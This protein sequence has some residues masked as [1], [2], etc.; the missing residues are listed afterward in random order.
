MHLRQLRAALDVPL[1][2]VVAAARVGEVVAVDAARVRQEVADR[3]GFGH[4]LVGHPEAGQIAAHGRVELDPSLVD[5]LHDEGRGPD[6]GDRADLEQGVGRRLDAGVEVEDSGGR[7]VD[8]VAA[9]DG[10]RGRRHAVSL[11]Q[12]LEPVPEHG[13]LR[14]RRHGQR[15]SFSVSSYRAVPSMLGAMGAK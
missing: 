1:E 14:R 15:A 8:L 7:G 9:E 13:H 6:L 11:A 10:D 12:L 5:E 3:H 4:R 2:R